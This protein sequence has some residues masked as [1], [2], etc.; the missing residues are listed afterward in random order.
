MLSL[1][2]RQF[3]RRFQPNCFADSQNVQF[4]TWFENRKTGKQGTALMD[5][6]PMII[7]F[8][9]TIWKLLFNE[10]KSRPTHD[11]QITIQFFQPTA[12][13]TLTPDSADPPT[14]TP[15]PVEPQTYSTASTA[16]ALAINPQR[17]A[18][19]S[20]KLAPSPKVQRRNRSKSPTNN[21][22]QNSASVRYEIAYYRTNVRILN[23]L[24][25]ILNYLLDRLRNIKLYFI[26]TLSYID[27]CYF[28]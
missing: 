15:T 25:S 9:M 23:Q 13:S 8:I 17:T 7:N 11:N 2:F 12:P 3:R 10:K 28:K 26:W 22:K 1:N 19:A 16:A 5:S 20:I 14:I 24:N 18:T 6:W 27:K 21:N 4:L